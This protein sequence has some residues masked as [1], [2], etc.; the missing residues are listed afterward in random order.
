MRSPAFMVKTSLATT[1]PSVSVS[2]VKGKFDQ[3]WIF[4]EFFK[5]TPKSCNFFLFLIHFLMYMYYY[6]MYV[7]DMI[8]L[9][10]EEK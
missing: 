2:L 9:I 5:L 3:I 7:D 4:T 8:L 6:T 1:T 10:V